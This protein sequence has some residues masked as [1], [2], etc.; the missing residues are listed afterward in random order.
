MHVEQ[1]NIRKVSLTDLQAEF[2]LDP[3]SVILEDFEPG[4]GKIVI[5]CFGKA[6]SAY[7]GGMGKKDIATFFCR[8]DEHYLA[9]KL[10]SV[11]DM[12]P[13][14]AA[15][16][17]Q[18]YEVVVDQRRR[19]VRTKHDARGLYD[20]LKSGASAESPD[21]LDDSALSDTLGPEW[22][23]DIPMKTNPD[24]QYLCRIIRAVQAGLKQIQASETQPTREVT[25]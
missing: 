11:D 15:L 25:T 1:S 8:C 4:R 14:Y 12:I 22:F 20:D 18:A 19:G 23:R 17:R 3:V 9:G 2:A 7:W 21:D 10:S 13:D 16:S 5:E 6:W 24:Y